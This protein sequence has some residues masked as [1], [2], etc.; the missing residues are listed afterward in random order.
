MNFTGASLPTSAGFDETWRGRR[1]P[2]IQRTFLT[3]VL[4][5]SASPVFSQA[6]FPGANVNMVSG[7]SWPG[8]DP[9]LQR[10]NEP[11]VAVSTRNASHILAGSNDYRTVDLSIT[12]TNNSRV[13]GD[14][15]LGVF[16]SFD[17]GQSWTSSLLPGCRYGAAACGTGG[18]GGQFYEAGADPVIRSGANGMFYYSA[19]AF[20]RNN[21][22]S[23]YFISR[24]I[25]DNNK[26]GKNN[27]T[28]RYLGQTVVDTG[29]SGQFVDREKY[30]WTPPSPVNTDHAA[31]TLPAGNDCAETPTEAG[32]KQFEAPGRGMS[33][34]IHGLSTNW[35]ELPVSITVCPK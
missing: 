31:Y 34:A 35:P 33:T 15:W 28:I 7:T 4:A 19:I 17:A 20:D 24:Y 14:A 21:N 26:E 32:M 9:W 13:I 11:A 30:T 1:G 3:L 23:A 27:D 12:D 2:G 10:Q 6:P 18:V 29:N 8:G 25:D 16:K 5:A 22:R